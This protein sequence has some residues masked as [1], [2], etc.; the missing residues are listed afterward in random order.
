M[1]AIGGGD[2]KRW[3]VQMGNK[4]RTV[5][6]FNKNI[7]NITT[8]SLS[9]HASA[10]HTITKFIIKSKVIGYDKNQFT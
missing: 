5:E 7:I 4:Q 6:Y 8:L 10:T 1:H 3:G 9:K 2:K